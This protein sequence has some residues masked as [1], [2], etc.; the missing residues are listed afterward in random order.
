VWL[1]PK[2]D[3]IYKHLHTAANRMSEVATENKNASGLTLRALKQATRELLLAQSSDWA[4]IMTTG[5]MV[6]Y[7]EKRTKEHIYNF[8]TLYEQIKNNNIN[9]SFLAN[10]EYVNNIFPD[11]DYTVFIR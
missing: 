7:A 10:L 11:V 3:W 9:E 4:F 1:N 2:N 5:T 8:T 6:E